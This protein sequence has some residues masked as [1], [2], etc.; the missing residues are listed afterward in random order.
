M[1]CE[2]RWDKAGFSLV[3][4][5]ISVSLIGIL[6]A[7]G[8]P[9]YRQFRLKAYQSEAKVQLAA[10]FTA[11]QSFYLQYNSY[12]PSLPTIG[13]APSGQTR[14]NIG[15][16]GHVG[17]ITTDIGDDPENYKDTKSI[18][19][20]A[21]GVG[22]DSRCNMVVLTP[23]IMSNAAVV[24]MNS[25]NAT[26]LAYEDMF[27]SKVSNNTPLQ[28]VASH[29][30]GL[31]QLVFASQAPVDPDVIKKT[32]LLPTNSWVDHWAINEK[33]EISTVKISPEKMGSGKV[34]AGTQT[35]DVMCPGLFVGIDL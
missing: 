31:S 8:L 13:F 30:F 19:T 7:I 1:I 15:F 14:Y 28:F 16:R 22:S 34:F 32:C 17:P 18:C 25:F 5:M 11:Q 24:T 29:V 33:K 6:V 26:A 12:F 3:E 10:V 21:G 27:A 2:R 35:L 9:Q 23:N 20:G 4:L